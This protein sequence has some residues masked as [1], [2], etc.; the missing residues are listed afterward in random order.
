[1]SSRHVSEL[2]GASGRH[3]V[4]PRLLVT[5]DRVLSENFFLPQDS[6]AGS[7]KRRKLISYSRGRIE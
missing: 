5:S 2:S 4:E 1:M 6:L 7:L 3:R